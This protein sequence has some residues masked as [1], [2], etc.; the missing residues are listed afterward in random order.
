MKLKHLEQ[1][2]DNLDTKLRRMIDLLNERR[3]DKT[4]ETKI[5]YPRRRPA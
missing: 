3:K 4:D 5:M 1:K 2:S